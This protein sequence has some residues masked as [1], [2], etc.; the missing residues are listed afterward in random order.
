M[1]EIENKINEFILEAISS[2][3]NIDI[4]NNEYFELNNS[5]KNI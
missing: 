2:K 3:K 1:L 5:L 4:I